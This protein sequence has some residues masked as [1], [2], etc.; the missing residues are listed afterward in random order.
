MSAEA[1]I[2]AAREE[3]VAVRAEL[4]QALGQDRTRRRAGMNRQMHELNR[5][6][7]PE[8][9][10]LSQAGQDRV[11]D[12]LLD[13]KTGGTFADVGGYDGYSGSNT[14]YFELHR[15]WTGV[16]VE[17][18]PAQLEKARV[19]RRCPCLGLAVA[20]TAGEADFIEV[21]EG[22]TQMSGLAETYEPG[23]LETVRNDPRHRESV[24]RVETR[25]LSDILTSSGVPDPDFLSLDIEGGEIAVLE[26]FPFDRHDVTI[27]SIENNTAT[28]RIPE[29][30]RDNGYDLV[31]FCGPDDIYHKRQAR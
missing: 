27:W 7:M 13:G 29:I 22:F 10:Y 5:M 9:R 18:V 31:E 30:L 28:G 21:K 1:R 24:L 8:Y 16:L 20:A 25:T 19:V 17:P 6:L 2:R 3:L 12:R 11:V 23:L 15:G 26:A 14:L 4:A